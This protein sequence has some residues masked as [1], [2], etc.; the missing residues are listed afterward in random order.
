MNFNQSNFD[1]LW[2]IIQNHHEHHAS[3]LST[4]TELK[5]TVIRGEKSHSMLHLMTADHQSLGRGQHG[6]SWVSGEGAV[7]LSLYVPMQS[8]T[9]DFGV[10]Q[11]SGLIALL[12]GFYLI[13]MPIITQMNQIRQTMNLPKIGVKWANDLGV[14]DED[15]Q[16][17]WKLAGILIEPVFIAKNDHRSLVGLVFGVGMNVQHAPIIQSGTYQATSL[18]TLW[19][20]SLGTLP[21][22]QDLYQPICKAI[23][24][25]I[26]HHHQLLTFQKPATCFINQFNQMHL[27]T[28]RQVEIF[29]QNDET[30]GHLSGKCLGID[31]RGA[32]LVQNEQGM[33]TIFAGTAKIMV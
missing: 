14:F 22:A 15:S 4:N 3:I 17:F 18:N 7:F 31:E 27:L 2:Q 6:R 10:N 16:R 9:Q 12:V 32:L 8:Q 19:S 33:Q 20:Q 30:S 21:S 11:L 29:T 28:D 5:N 24:R 26:F 13:K 25:A 23:C 1:Q